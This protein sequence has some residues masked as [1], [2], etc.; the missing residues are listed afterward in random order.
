MT[1]PITLS[2]VERA[3]ERLAPWLEPTPLRTY[4][5]LDQAVPGV[6]LHVKHENMQPTGSFKVRN[7]LSTVTALGDA[8]RKRGIVGATTGNHGL[9]LAYAGRQLSVPV[10]ICVPLNN[11]PEKNSALRAW[12]ATVVE[13]G[14]DYD[15]AVAVASRLAAEREVTLAHSTNN[16]NVLSGAGTMTLE[17]VEQTQDLDVLLIAVGGGSQAVGAMTVA[18]ALKPALQIIGIQAAGASTAHDA[19]HA[20]EPRQGS[21]ADTFAEG[22]AT[23]STYE[24]TFPALLEGLADFVTVTDAE[25]AEGVRIILATT[26]H[27]VEGA[28]AM[29]VAAA[30]KL[31]DQLAGKSVGVVFCGANMDTG[32]L[33]R[34]LNREL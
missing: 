25:I 23:R 13:E 4:P 19:W 7:G 15:E 27:L 34:I 10:T 14:K 9:G 11:N 2:D 17:L 3:R 30:I 21:R 28:G 5:T 22:V 29:G 6:H 1:S 33:R 20:R 24:L 16:V 8:E 18:R 31:R 26:H 12:G 32:V